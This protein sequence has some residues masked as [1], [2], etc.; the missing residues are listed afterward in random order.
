MPKMTE[1]HV[2][3]LCIGCGLEPEEISVYVQAVRGSTQTPSEYVRR[4]EGTLNPR[5]GH[6]LCDS[7][8]IDAGMPTAPGGWVAP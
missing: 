5:N 8:Y 3:P 6:F 7:C 1:P 4:N 2:Q